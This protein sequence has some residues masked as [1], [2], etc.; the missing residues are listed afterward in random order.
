MQDQ[1]NQQR[2]Y[3]TPPPRPES[4]EAVNLTDRAERA[5]EQAK[6]A[7]IDRV[8]SVRDQAQN[9][10]D[11]GRSQ[12]VERI[13]RVSSVLKSAGSELRKNDET[14]ARYVA[15]AGDKVETVASYVSSAEP[16]RVLR[17]VQDLARRQPAWFFGGAFLLGLA[18]GRF[19]KASQER[20]SYESEELGDDDF[21]KSSSS[22]GPEASRRQQAY[23]QRA[24][25]P[26]EPRAPSP[27]SRP[28]A[29]SE[30][31]SVTD[32]PT[33]PTPGMPRG[34]NQT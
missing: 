25:A 29:P 16:D 23:A 4:R 13:R 33:A 5:A 2:T 19:L 27:P 12:V 3:G 21:L 10:I 11:Q 9:G 20:G 1:P 32:G 24:Y 34:P 28:I 18:G 17:D 22:Y 31:L 8:Q 26:P 6:S 30:T 15:A 14:I 7:A